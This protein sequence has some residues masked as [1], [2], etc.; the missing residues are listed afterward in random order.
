[1]KN[2]KNVVE[3]FAV[4]SNLVSKPALFNRLIDESRG[5]KGFH[6]YT[7]NESCGDKSEYIRDGMQWDTWKQNLDTAISSD[8]FDGINVMCTISALALEGLVD[9][10]K[11]CGDLKR[12]NDRKWPQFSLNI[13]RFPNFQSPL[14]LPLDIRKKVSGQLEQFYKAYGDVLNEMEISN[15]KR[16][17]TYLSQEQLPEELQKNFKNYFIQYD[18]RRGKDFEK[19]FSIIGEWYSGI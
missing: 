19:T 15:C 1:L 11:F 5:I 9:F 14:V 13:L 8:N 17:V 4:N 18:K 7:S 12:N 3:Y 2:R 6:L 10:L 16:L